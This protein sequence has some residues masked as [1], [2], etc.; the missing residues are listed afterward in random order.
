MRGTRSKRTT[1]ALFAGVLMMSFVVSPTGIAVG[2]SPVVVERGV[3]VIELGAVDRL[4]Q[5]DTGGALVASQSITTQGCRASLG[6]AADLATLEALPAGSDLGLFADGIGVQTAGPGGGN[7]QPCGRVD[8]PNEGLV[9]ALG[10]DLAGLDVS[11]AE[12]DIEGKFNADVVA[13]LFDD[14]TQVASVVLGTGERSDSGPDSGDGDNYRWTIDPGA[15]GVDDVVF[16]EAVF[17]VSTETPSG[18]F[19]LEGGADGTEAGSLGISGSAFKLVTTFDGIVDCGDDT[20]TAGN[21]STEAAATF[22]R[23]D[24]DAVK[25]GGCTQLI[26]YNL[27]STATADDQTVTFEFETEEAPSWFGTIT[28]APEEAQVPVPPTEVDGEH[29]EWCDGFDGTD[30][31]TQLPKPVLP[32][33]DEWCL[34]SQESE[35]FGPGEIQVTQ[36]IYGESDPGFIR[37]K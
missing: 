4:A 11:R 12:L 16:D 22:T 32:G 8:G 13:T 7:G 34:V 18:A 21:G 2:Q 23:G 9:W 29:L 28:W 35:V 6:A 31:A 24:D 10:G 5:Y 14:G 1:F 3:L 15:D 37:P 26:G 25:G 30:D 17:T 36:T 33:D 20:L 19:S 27:D